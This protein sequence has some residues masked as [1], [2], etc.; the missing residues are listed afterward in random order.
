MKT[1]LIKKAKA[2]V[3]RK[4][5][6]KNNLVKKRPQRFHC[7]KQRYIKKLKVRQIREAVKMTARDLKKAPGSIPETAAEIISS[8]RVN[9]I[10]KSVCSMNSMNP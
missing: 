2:K 5:M 3:E 4:K 6:T 7:P 9:E 1:G 8:G 10:M